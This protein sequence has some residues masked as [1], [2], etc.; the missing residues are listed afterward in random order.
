MGHSIVF[1][2]S[3]TARKIQKTLEYKVSCG[4]LSFTQGATLLVIKFKK[5]VYQNEIASSLY[6]ESASLVTVIDGLEKLGLVERKDLA[7]DRRKYK[8]VLT[9]KGV[10]VSEEVYNQLKKLNAVIKK[11]M[12]SEEYFIFCQTL[13]KVEACLDYKN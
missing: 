7:E 11:Q 3:S 2:I 10:Q 8:I 4:D 6:L 5:E 13:S 12:T 9:P 1:H